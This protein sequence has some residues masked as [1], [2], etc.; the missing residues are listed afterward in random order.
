MSAQAAPAGGLRNNRNFQRLFA[1]QSIS[2]IGDSVFIVTVMLWIA[3]RIAAGEHWAPA[4]VSGALIASAVPALAVGPFA[5]VWVD[6]WNRRRTMLTADAARCILIACLLVLPA[7]RTELPVGVQLGILYAVLAVAGAFGEFFDPSRLAVIGVIVPTEDQPQASGRLQA[8]MAFAQVIGP[9]VAAPLLLLFGPSWALIVDAASYGISFLC[10]RAIRM[11]APSETDQ[12]RDAER[13]SFGAELRAGLRFFAG[14]KVLVAIAVS[15]MI[16]MLGAGAVNALAVFFVIHNLHVS[17]GW[18]GVVS[19]AVGVGAIAGALSGG[20][21]ANRVRPGRLLWI[22]MIGAGLILIALACCTAI[23]PAL[24]AC[25]G[26]GAGVGVVNAMDGPIMLR[27]TPSHMIGRVSAVFSPLVQLA[28]VISMALAGYLASTALRQ[29]HLVVAGVT[30]GPYNTLFAIGGILF[31]LS[32]A[33]TIV[34][35]RGIP[36]ASPATD[37]SA[38][39]EPGAENDPVLQPDAVS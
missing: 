25:F 21:V 3:T 33:A 20:A 32:G 18:L 22:G 9:P 39:A 6:R 7:L 28:S 34:P 16:A 29:F 15:G 11:P 37:P 38:G 17:A 27:T 23:V 4:A 5:G 26:L 2:I 8:T 1:G 12:S 19:A 35:L 10:I 14:S 31:V 13:A 36:E 30:F 24:I